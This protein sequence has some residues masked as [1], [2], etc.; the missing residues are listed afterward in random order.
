MKTIA[1]LNQRWWYRLVKVISLFILFLVMGGSIVAIFVQHN[2][3]YDNNK[4]YVQCNDGRKFVL[5]ENGIYLYSGYMDI[6]S[7]EKA[8]NLCKSDFA[9]LT[10][11]QIIANINALEEQ[12]ASQQEVQEWLDSI[13]DTPIKMTREEYR[14]K[15]GTFPPEAGDLTLQ[16]L[17]ATGGKPAG[18]A[19]PTDSNYQ[20]VSIYASRDW[21]R[22]TGFSLFVI[23]GYL[24]VFEAVRRT[25]YYVLLGKFMPK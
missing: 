15:Y 4:S 8:R 5:S 13:K 12:G 25:F 11:E 20:L 3:I 18:Q 19:T 23:L 2:P 9:A 21:I 6:Y 24:V 17:L 1:E 16:E 7:F 14:E 22:I 10:R